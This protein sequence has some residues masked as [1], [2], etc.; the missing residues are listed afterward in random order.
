MAGR[1]APEH[2]AAAQKV[3]VQNLQ[4][5]S[6]KAAKH[7]LTLLLE[8]L[9][10]KDAPGYFY[11]TVDEASVVLR[12]AQRPNIKLMFDAYHVGM[13]GEDVV[14]A[15]QRHF[16]SIGHVQFAAVPTRAEPDE[17]TLDYAT[18]I[19]ILGRRGYSGWIGAEYKPRGDTDAG[20]SWLA[21]CSG[22]KGQT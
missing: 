7:G 3:F 5:A 11:S 22:K 21:Q 10:P 12:E 9:N 6:A 15:L 16:A 18:I 17:G 20:L 4:I 2:R 8:P 19:D 14:D 13:I 1:V